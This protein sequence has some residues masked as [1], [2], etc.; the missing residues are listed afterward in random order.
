MLRQILR[1]CLVGILNTGIDLGVLNLLLWWNPYVGPMQYPLYKTISFLCAL[2]NSFF[3]NRRFTFKR[4][5]KISRAQLVRFTVVTVF[6]FLASVGVPSVVYVVLS[7]HSGLS[8]ILA[9][10]IGALVGVGASLVV[11]FIGYKYIVFTR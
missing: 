7:I 5:D 4:V 1:F 3:M 9:A 6:G 10:N 8:S 2:I 11:N